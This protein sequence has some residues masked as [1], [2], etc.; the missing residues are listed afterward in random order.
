MSSSHHIHGLWTAFVCV[1]VMTIAAVSA[2]QL[3][4]LSG[5]RLI[6]H[7]AL[8]P[9]RLVVAA[10]PEISRRPDF[11]KTRDLQLQSYSAQ[12]QEMQQGMILLSLD[13]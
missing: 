13:I 8:S 11:A 9:G 4:L 5:L 2:D 6:L 12:F 10:I 1:L 7:D 3:Q